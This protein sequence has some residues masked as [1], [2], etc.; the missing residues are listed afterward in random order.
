MALI[1]FLRGVNV[2]GNKS[3]RPSQLAGELS[4][5]DVTSHGAAGTFVVRGKI[6]AKSLRSRIEQKLPFKAEVMICQ[7]AELIRRVR[8]KPFG[9][10]P[11]AKPARG[12]LSI[13]EKPPRARL[14]LPFHFLTKSRWEV[15]IV[16][17][18][19]RF[20]FS[21]WHRRGQA[22]VYPNQVVEKQLGVSATTRGW[23]TIT[24]ICDALEG[25]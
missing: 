15:R 14:K 5:L 13:M 17:I 18:D 8:G 12:F 3:F 9:P 19:G 6:D 25:Q 23:N 20:A 22:I 24:A 4:R 2:G 21:L 16:R 10:K 1:V 11:P 7:A